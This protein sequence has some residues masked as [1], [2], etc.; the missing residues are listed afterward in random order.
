MRFTRLLRQAVERIVSFRIQPDRSG[1]QC[2][3]RHARECRYVKS[4]LIRIIHI[5]FKRSI[6][7]KVG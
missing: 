4:I 1:V 6:S 2:I 7:I 3:D 5:K